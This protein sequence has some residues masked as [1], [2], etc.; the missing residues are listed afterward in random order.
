[1]ALNKPIANDTKESYRFPPLVSS[2]IYVCIKYKIIYV[3]KFK[4]PYMVKSTGIKRMT[5]KNILIL[6]ITFLC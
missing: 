3:Y 5:K 2:R 4:A 6:Q 1:M